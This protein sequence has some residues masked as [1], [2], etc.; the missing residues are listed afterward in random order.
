MLQGWAYGMC[1]RAAL[2]MHSRG[3]ELR[4]LNDMMKCLGVSLQQGDVLLAME[5]YSAATKIN[6]ALTEA[7]F[8][9]ALHHFNK[10]LVSFISSMAYQT[11]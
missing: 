10:Q 8:R 5:D 1:I 6:P 2:G 11:R 7:L 9:H 3:K 4:L